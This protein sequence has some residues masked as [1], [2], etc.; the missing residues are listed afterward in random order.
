MTAPINGLVIRESSPDI[1]SGLWWERVE[2]L[3]RFKEI[4][5]EVIYRSFSS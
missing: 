3:Y 2:K 1:T 4:L 5:I